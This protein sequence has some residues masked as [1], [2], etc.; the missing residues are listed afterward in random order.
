[1]A[2]NPEKYALA[3]MEALLTD[4]T[5][6]SCYCDEKEQKDSLS[7]GERRCIKMHIV[8]LVDHISL[9][10]EKWLSSFQREN[11]MVLCHSVHI[12]HPNVDTG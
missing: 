11:I 7:N 8:T 3:L 10:L 1:M 9:T 5:A 4:E 2:F 6:S 12:V